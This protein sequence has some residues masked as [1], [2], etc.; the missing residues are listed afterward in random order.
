[1]SLASIR[2]YAIATALAYVA[3]SS[4]ASPASQACP[5]PAESCPYQKAPDNS[6]KGDKDLDN[7][8]ALDTK[9]SLS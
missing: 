2:C 1:M 6:K 3:V 5:F 7:A 9:V 8:P 4:Q